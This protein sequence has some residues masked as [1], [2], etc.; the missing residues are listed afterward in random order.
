VACEHDGYR[1]I[2]ARYD[3]AVGLLTYHWRCEKCGLVLHEV[4]RLRYRPRFAPLPEI[5]YLQRRAAKAVR[6]PGLRDTS[7]LQQ[8]G[9]MPR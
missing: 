9:A 2:V 3:R 7:E 4:G 1:E 8:L 6:R 5:S